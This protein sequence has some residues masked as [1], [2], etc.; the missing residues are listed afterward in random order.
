MEKQLSVY[1]V[2]QWVNMSYNNST[3]RYVPKR[4]QNI[5]PHKYWK[6]NVSSGIIHNSPK[7]E[8]IQWSNEVRKKCDT[9]TYR[10][11]QDNK[12]WW[13]TNTSYVALPWKH[14]DKWKTTTET[15][16][17]QAS[18][19]IKSGLMLAWR[20]EWRDP[21]ITAVAGGPLSRVTKCPHLE[22]QWW[23]YKLWA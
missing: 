4:T 17:E 1:K 15:T 20:K 9:A 11:T 7:P 8:A 10:L 13:H 23:L 3:H 5:R 12:K 6:T 21:R 19:Q 16:R 22:C 2:R 14:C 18:L